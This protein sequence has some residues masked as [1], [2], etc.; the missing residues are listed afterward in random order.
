[1]D[2]NA[3]HLIVGQVQQT[4]S[5]HDLFAGATNPAVPLVLM[6]SGGS[7]SVA[8]LHLMTQLFPD[9]ITHYTVLHVNHLL[10]GGPAFADEESV[11]LLA[12]A[13]N[14]RCEVERVDVA[15]LAAERSSNDSIEQ[16]GRE[17]RYRLANALLDR[18]CD[19]AGIARELGLIV[20]AHTLD[21][22]A[23]TFFMRSIV[24]A[25]TGGLR[26][27]PFRNGRVIRPLLDCT[28]TN[29]QEWLITEGRTWREDETNA[30]TRYSRAYMRHEILS[31]LSKRNPQTLAAMQRTMNILTDEDDYLS[32]LAQALEA[33]F[34][35]VE[36]KTLLVSVALLEKPLRLV[37]RVLHTICSRIMPSNQRVTFEHIEAI[38]KRGSTPGF[39]ITLPGNVEV[40]NEYGLLR[41]LGQMEQ[42]GCDS[43]RNN[44]LISLTRINAKDLQ[45][46]PVV[47]AR[48]N[49]TPTMIFVD[50]DA[51][52]S[53]DLVLTSIHNGDRFCPLGM[54]GHERLV[55]DVLID[56]KLP[57]RYRGNVLILRSNGSIVWIVGVQQDDRYKV[58]EKTTTIVR[59]TFTGDTDWKTRSKKEQSRQAT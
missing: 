47:Y 10:R 9:A 29:L 32:E 48:M 8:L 18:L 51:L 53:D 23:E 59:I 6:V 17:E 34:V 57:A 37:R 15:A 52:A 13:L 55:S 14:L 35:F 45:L 4:I 44:E 42:G 22:R 2:K 16:V 25:G 33:Q 38:A 58:K 12:S 56:R 21:D 19:E 20:T 46:D 7:D 40:R 41:F 30:D 5:A 50:A 36:D 31:R 43:A 28:R 3:S 39:A 24:G 54:N 26:S 49:A 11:T 27:I 1:V